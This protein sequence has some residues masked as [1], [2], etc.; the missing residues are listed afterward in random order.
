MTQTIYPA[1]R[2]RDADASLQ[3]LKAAFGAEEHAV[4]RGADGAIRHVELRIQGN[5]V[6]FGQYDKAGFLGGTAPDPLSSTVGLYVVVPE[7]DAA[8][9]RAV[10]A[11]ARVVRGLEDTDYGSREFSV[12]DLE[13]NLWSFGTYDPSNV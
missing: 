1:I 13:G 2:Y 9:D 4:Y 3:W 8:H 5:I 7:P 12:R 6:M 10:A 11:G